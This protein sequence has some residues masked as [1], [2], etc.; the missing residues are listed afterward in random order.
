MK[1][2]E[3]ILPVIKLYASLNQLSPFKNEI[4][5]AR[6]AGDFEREREFI[7]KAT[8]S[9]GKHLVKI[10]GIDLTVTGKENL[11]DKGPVV[12][13]TNHQGYADIPVTCAALDKFQFGYVAKS[14][15]E[16]L[17]FYGW[18]MKHIRSVFIKRDDA[19]AALRAMDEGTDLIEKGFSL[20][21]FPEGTRSKGGPVAEFKK[22][23][24]RL[25]TK[26]GV[27]I[28]PV[29]INGTHRAFEDNGYIK[30]GARV[31]LVIHPAIATKGIDKLS[32]GN[33]ISEI[34]SIVKGDLLQPELCNKPL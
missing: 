30:S 32:A 25:A 27:P 19:R 21:I 4:T 14:D 33:L 17:P 22:G 24:L 23:S 18:W 31:D 9:W 6:N 7:L 8:T 26:P 29:T 34:E 11:P 12:F 5:R 20:L 1:I 3:N 28:I 15:L 16:K 10:Y 2:F 13:A